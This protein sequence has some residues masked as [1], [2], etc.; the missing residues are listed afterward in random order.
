MIIE[1]DAKPFS[2][3]W[4]R[5]RNALPFYMQSLL[6]RPDRIGQFYFAEKH[7]WGGPNWIGGEV[8]TGGRGGI[9]VGE[10]GEVE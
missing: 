7:T 5:G 2:Y 6:L 4:R 10:V 9:R 1:G 8:Q 3:L